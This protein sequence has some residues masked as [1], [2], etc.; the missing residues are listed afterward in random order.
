M[1]NRISKHLSI[2]IVCMDD[3]KVNTFQILLKYLDSDEI[4]ASDKYLTLRLKLTKTLIWKGCPE[5]EADT[6]ADE[7]LD[8]VAKKIDAIRQK[9]SQG[10]KEENGKEIKQ[11]E[12]IN[13][14][15]L[16]V[17]RFVLLEYFRKNPLSPESEPPEIP[18][19]PVIEI[20]EEPDLRLRCLRKCIAEKIPNEADKHLILGYY[21]DESDEKNKVIREKLRV[22][23]GL[24]KSNFKKKACILRQRLEKC[25]NECVAKLTVTK[26]TISDTNKQ[27]VM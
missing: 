15:S 1:L 3:Q 9:L 8:R 12:N 22:K 10:I 16:E 23:L 2:C 27:E 20:L 6:L 21:T 7:I 13:A 14:Y 25:I 19:Q 26:P 17:M 18:V 11:I 24:T 4:I 5:V